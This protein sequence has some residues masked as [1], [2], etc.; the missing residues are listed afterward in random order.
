MHPALQITLGVLATIA[1]IAS[2]IAAWKSQVSSHQALEFQ[3]RLA[4]HQDSIFLIRSTIDRLL[5][6]KRILAN[7][8]LASDEEFGEV[9]NIHRQIQKNLESLAQ[10]NVIPPSDSLLF[11]AESFGEIIDQMTISNEEIDREVSRLKAKI[12]EIFS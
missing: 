12:D 6:L 5:Q 2:A 11:K 9:E 7:P 8:L 4:R 3:K 1:A 10:S